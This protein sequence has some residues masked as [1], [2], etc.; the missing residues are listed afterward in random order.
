[1]RCSV[2]GHHRN[3]GLRLANRARAA[4]AA[5]GDKGLSERSPGLAVQ[6]RAETMSAK[7]IAWRKWE[8]P[9]TRAK[10]LE[11]FIGLEIINKACDLFLLTRKLK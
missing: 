11:R 10:K 5:Q 3:S 8:K 6:K 9:K 1:L 2:F 4:P 7:G